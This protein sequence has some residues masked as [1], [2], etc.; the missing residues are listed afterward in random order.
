MQLQMRS[1]M[2][3]IGLE[4]SKPFLHLRITK[5]QI[6]LEIKEPELHIR[7]LRPVLHIDQTQCFA[8][9]GKRTLSAFTAYYA[10]R[11]WADALE[12]IARRA[13]EGDMLAQIH[14]GYTIEKLAAQNLGEIADFN[15]TAIPKQPPRVWFDTYPVQ[16]EFNPG[17]VDTRLQRGRVEG[18]FQWGKVNIY[19]RQKN[20]L[21]INW[22]EDSK[23]DLIA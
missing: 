19:L 16:Y 4:I 22:V 1:Q 15:V 13:Q 23:V 18:Y 21:E 17:D 2:A 12:G 14:K 5:P 6:N 8:D 10:D 7:S 11:G 3:L 9:A 20:Y